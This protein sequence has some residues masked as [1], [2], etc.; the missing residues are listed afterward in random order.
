[1]RREATAAFGASRL[2]VLAVAVLA[3]EFWVDSSG[4]ANE[5]KF[6]DPS[7]T[8]PFGG[9]AGDLLSPL[10]RWDSTWFLD[11]ADDGYEGGL[12]TAFFPL[13]PLLVRALVLPFASEGALLVSAYAVSLGCFLCAL[14]LL[15][16]LV[17]LELGRRV[18]TASVWL[19]ALFPAAIYFGAPYSESLFLLASVGAFYAARTERWALA[20]VAAAAASATR[21][22]GLVLLVPLV[23]L[24]LDSQ[25]R[26]PSGLAWL[27][28]APLGLGAYALYLGL[29][30]GDALAF[31]DAQEAWYREF[32]GPFVGAWDG[33]VA[34]WDGA[35]IDI[36]LFGFLV[37]AAAALVGTFRRLPLAYGAY[38]LAALAL[39]LSFPV[40]PQPLMS[41]PRF[42][43]V[44]FPLFIWLAVVTE[45]RGRTVPVAMASA[46]GL[47][48][49]TERFA[50]WE[51]IA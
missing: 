27:G 50:S 12:D 44:L 3:A 38:A 49:F 37:F 2:L 47:A 48:L 32:A 19:L 28:L 21:S 7:L 46:V 4:E 43:A 26:R 17:E 20:G 29:E 23:L 45:E 11:I 10:A 25:R 41:L 18:A 51:W 13:Y 30:H 35:S 9:V 42:V 1:L 22:A 34:A 8:H 5:A 40:D 24:W 6:G 14:W 39:P 15:H 36:V 31:L 16:R 33:A